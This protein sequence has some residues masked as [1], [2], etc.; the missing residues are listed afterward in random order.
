MRTPAL[1]LTILLCTSFVG[2]AQ[3]THSISEIQGQQ[4][5]S[6][7]VGSIVT[8]SGIVTANN[9]TSATSGVIGYFIQDGEG[10]WNGIYVYDQI[11][12]PQIGDE[13]IIEGE[14]AE[15][16]DVTELVGISYF[17]T[18]SSGNDLPSPSIVTTGELASSEAYEGCLVQIV[19]AMCV[20]P[21][22][23]YGEAIFDDGSGEV[24]TNDY[25]FWPEEGWIQDEYYSIT[26]CIHYT[27]EEYKIEPRYS[28]DIVQVCNPGLDLDLGDWG[29]FPDPSLGQQFE[30]V[31]VG[32][33]YSD[34]FTVVVPNTASAI[35][36]MFLLPLDSIE[37]LDIQLIN[38]ET[39]GIGLL[40]DIGIQ[41]TCNNL[42][43]SN[44]E[45]IFLSG[46]Q[47][48]L[49]LEGIATD[50]GTY[51]MTMNLDAWVTVFDV[52]VA[53][54]FTIDGYTLV[55][56]GPC[57]NDEACNYGEIGNCEFP[58]PPFDCSGN[59]LNDA[60]SDG[61]CDEDEILGCTYEIACN[62]NP[63]AT[64]DDDSCE[65]YCPGC[66][67]LEACNF[68]EGAIQDDGTC[69]YPEDLYGSDVV[70]CSGNCLNDEDLDGVCDPNE[71]FGCTNGLACNFIPEATEDDGA[72]EF[73]SCSGCTYEYACNYDP[74]ALYSDGSCV[75]GECSGCTDSSAC[76]FN[77]TVAD[78]DGSCTYAPLGYD[79]DGSCTLDENSDGICDV[80]CIDPSACN[81]NEQATIDDGSCEL[82]ADY[83]DCD[84]TC[85]NDQDGDGYCD[86]LEISGCTNSIACNFDPVATDDN[87]LCE[88][89]CG[90]GTAW[91][92]TSLTCEIITGFGEEVC[93]DGTQWDPV[94]QTCQ[95]MDS[96]PE[97][98]D[99]DGIVTVSDLLQLLGSFGE[100]CEVS[101][102]EF[103][104]G[105]PL[106][107]QGYDYA[108]VQI[109]E[110]CW[111]AENLRT[112]YYQNGDV[113]PNEPEAAEW[114]TASIGLQ[115]IYGE[116][117][118]GVPDSLLNVFYSDYGLLYNNLSVHDE[119]NI[120]PFNWHVPSDEEWIDL[121]VFSGMSEVE[122][123]SF[124]WR[125]TG[126]GMQLKST[127]EDEPSWNGSN[128]SGFSALPGG[129]RE[130]N[131]GYGDVLSYGVFWTSSENIWRDLSTDE[132]RV[133]RGQGNINGGFSVR[134]LKDTE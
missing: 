28:D 1:C 80:G 104:C 22:A 103:T 35:D 88:Y 40:G 107:Y 47:Y 98:L 43:T 52:G 26:G 121:E 115:T 119:R 46:G 62:Y 71:I 67:D 129:N 63:N 16:Y 76:N 38:E 77:P 132:D 53:Q 45:C 44:S 13:I 108:T 21:D 83:F 60:D 94:T 14:V 50:P 79:C 15:F 124:G 113:I 102:V 122:A 20:N 61:I 97:D 55:V 32:V 134:C 27:F 34:V 84:G 49:T 130:S 54:P 42:N 78:D 92:D 75:F 69:F 9:V 24:K 128:L 2:H 17:E 110:Q 48:C 127:S 73:I 70:D 120:C 19:N 18:V 4:F 91:N 7:L 131:G 93:G 82:P 114:S 3:L 123:H 36:P 126:I 96:C 30:T 41:T 99:G 86:E 5:T 109:G 10:P 101:V 25:M 100:A 23:D 89:C 118:L 85:I 72:C 112:E 11:Q 64:E 56:E 106:S 133:R 105:N 51:S 111:F 117:V 59:C 95:T 81:Y 74:E 65:F 37:I 29:Y 6:P 58:I 12:A 8:T 33:P 66:T 68:D 31:L 125:G 39:G 116:G 87:G 90:T 57:E